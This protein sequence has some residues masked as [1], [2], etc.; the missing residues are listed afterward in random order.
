MYLEMATVVHKLCDVISCHPSLAA[1]AV[2]KVPR[3]LIPH[4]PHFFGR[5]RDSQLV[6]AKIFP[7]CFPFHKNLQ[8]KFLILV[9]IPLG[10]HPNDIQYTG[11]A[12]RNALMRIN[13]P[14]LDKYFWY[15]MLS[16]FSILVMSHIQSAFL[17]PR[18]F[19]L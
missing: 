7:G 9:R 4:P 11:V 19:N 3:L 13:L 12:S 5:A 2:E 17:Y 18:G 8:H 15:Q 1:R 10:I 16:R 6:Q 14:A